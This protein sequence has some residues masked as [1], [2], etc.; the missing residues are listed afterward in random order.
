MPMAKMILSIKVDDNGK[1]SIWSEKKV[2]NGFLNRILDRVPLEF[3][4]LRRKWYVEDR[5]LD[6]KEK[7]KKDD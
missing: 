2:T 6:E 7:V 5:K 4:R 1:I 3:N